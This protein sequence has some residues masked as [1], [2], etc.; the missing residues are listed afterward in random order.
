M[1]S[2]FNSRQLSLWLSGVALLSFLG[3]TFID[4]GYVFPEFGIDMPELLPITLGMLAFYGGWL[5]ALI[6]STRGSRAGFMAVLIFNVLLLL[7][8]VST[9]TLLCPSPCETAWPLGE[10]LMWSN[11]VIGVAAILATLRAI[12]TTV[13]SGIPAAAENR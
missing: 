11:I 6:S 5:W 10:Y 3:R 13:G 7:F 8:G 1:K 12:Q 2:I 4:Y 9:F